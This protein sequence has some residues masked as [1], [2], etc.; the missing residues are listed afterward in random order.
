MTN[1]SLLIMNHKKWIEFERKE[2]NDRIIY[3]LFLEGVTKH[4]PYRKDE[5]KNNVFP[6]QRKDI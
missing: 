5:K 1:S 6:M 4:N 2:D 3:K